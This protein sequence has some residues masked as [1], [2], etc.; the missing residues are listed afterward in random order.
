M[1]ADPPT[2]IKEVLNSVCD[3]YDDATPER[4]RPRASTL[5]EEHDMSVRGAIQ[6]I[7]AYF[8]EDPSNVHRIESIQTARMEPKEATLVGVVLTIVEHPEKNAREV[9]LS[10]GTG[11]IRVVLPAPK[12]PMDAAGEL[13]VVRHVGVKNDTQRWAYARFRTEVE[14]YGGVVVE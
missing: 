8:A 4:V 3:R 12:I 11:Q 13:R 2:K 6:V 10:D 9:W 5:L 1:I 14:R 7:E